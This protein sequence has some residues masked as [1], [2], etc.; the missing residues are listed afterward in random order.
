M[1]AQSLVNAVGRGF[2]ERHYDKI[3]FGGPDEC[4]LWTASTFGRGYGA[5]R[6]G[7]KQRYAHRMAYEAANGPIPA[8]Q[9]VVRH[10]CDV[11]ACVNPAHLELGTQADNMRDMVE[12]GRHR[13]APSK[14]EAHG[15]AKLTEADVR[16]I[17][18]LY[19]RGCRE[20][21]AYALARRFGVS[22]ATISKIARRASWAHMPVEGIAA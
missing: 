2:F 5:A 17:R 6:M 15:C 7:G 22:Q 16:S 13:A 4:W 20:F 8:D 9:P 3:K 12:R 21:G 10:K 11:K 14:G 18:A 1:M 19:V